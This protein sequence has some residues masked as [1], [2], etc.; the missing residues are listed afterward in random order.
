MQRL[1]RTQPGGVLAQFALARVAGTFAAASLGAMAIGAVA[2]GRLILRK[3]SIK[4]ARFSRVTIGDLSVDRLRVRDFVR[5][6]VPP[7][8]I[9]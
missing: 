8:P 3:L 5:D 6:D 4:D 2:I 9:R 7:P 1:Q